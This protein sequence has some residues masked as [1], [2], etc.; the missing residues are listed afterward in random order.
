[1]STIRWTALFAVIWLFFGVYG[2]AAVAVGLYIRNR[3]E[4]R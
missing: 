1:M 4:N 3:L 2:I